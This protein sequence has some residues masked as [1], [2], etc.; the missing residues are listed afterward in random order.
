M[1]K[2]LI[3][4]AIAA[5]GFSS[6]ALAHENLGMMDTQAL[7]DASELAASM[8][9][10]PTVYGNIQLAITYDNIEGNEVGGDGWN[11]R[12]N[13]S[14]IGIKHDHEL[15]P[16]WTAFGKIE[17]EGISADNKSQSEGLSALD[18][19]YI[20]VESD[21]FGML[22]VGSDDSQ[23]E[24]LIDGINQYYEVFTYNF[25]AGDYQTGEGDLIQYTS[26]SFSGLTLHAAVSFQGSQ[27]DAYGEKNFPYQLG[28]Q[29]SADMFSVAV[30]MDSNDASDN[31]SNSY[32]IH[33]QVMPIEE[34]TLGAI[35]AFREGDTDGFA[36]AQL[37]ELDDE[38]DEF[39]GQS[40]AGIYG[41]YNLGMNTFAL[42]YEYQE[43]DEGDADASTITVQALRNL[44]D[45]LYVYVE[46]YFNNTDA[47]DDD[48]A[49]NSQ[50]A[51][52]GAYLF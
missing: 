23:Y 27:D 2:T 36:D 10:M 29:Y 26:P 46:G 28:V 16:G 35:Y 52:G 41:I 51:V 8:D 6:V 24:V 12:D 3:A 30:A 45:N 48:S 11:H 13:G 22:W 42:S 31:T 18:E 38:L 4:S 47:D 34:L 33:A 39:A 43:G 49:D 50:F 19:A 7:M 40:Y 17:L 5:A 37:N 25:K 14:T 20:G 44:S 32:G 9:A 21:D 15:A 1:K